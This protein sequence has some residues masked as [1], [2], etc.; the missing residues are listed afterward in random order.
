VSIAGSR[1]LNADGDQ[2]YQSHQTGNIPKGETARFGLRDEPIAESQL[3]RDKK[4][5]QSRAGHDAQ[6]P[7]LGKEQ[8]D[9]LAK[10]GPVSG[11]ILNGQAGHA[12]G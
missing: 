12:Y 10:T 7:N 2:E 3:P 8:D 1:Q 11:G 9:T 5:E 6:A 4:R